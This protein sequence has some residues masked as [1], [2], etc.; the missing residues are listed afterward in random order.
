L[1]KLI[2]QRNR[3]KNERLMKSHSALVE[4]VEKANKAK[5]RQTAEDIGLEDV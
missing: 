4:K 2:N 1:G 5:G 3:V